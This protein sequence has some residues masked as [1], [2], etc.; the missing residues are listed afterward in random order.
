MKNFTPSIARTLRASAIPIDESYNLEL[1]LLGIRERFRFDPETNQVN[2]N[3]I[4]GFLYDVIDLNSFERF[5]VYI[6]EPRPLLP[7]DSVIE[8][9]ENGERIFVE[10]FNLVISFYID[11][12]NRINHS[13]RAQEVHLIES[14]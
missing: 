6:E 4:I 14:N 12:T 5:E 13:I 7:M 11:R 8:A 1:T 10:F 3:E 9:R 2:K